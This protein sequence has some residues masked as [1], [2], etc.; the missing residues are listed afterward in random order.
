MNENDN[1]SLTVVKY[2][3]NKYK[4]ID[5]EE[6]VKREENDNNNNNDDS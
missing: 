6:T 2:T 1:E 3:A 5:K 4:K